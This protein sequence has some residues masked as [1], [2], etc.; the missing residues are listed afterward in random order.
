MLLFLIALNVFIDPRGI[1]GTNKYPVIVATARIEKQLHLESMNP[2]PKILIL[3][4]SHCMRF[5]PE[6]VEDATGLRTFNLSVNSGKIEDFLALLSYAI[7]DQKIT[8]EMVILGVDPRTFCSIEDE[9][10]DKRLISNMTLMNHVPLNYIKRLQKKLSLY[11][12]TLNLNYIKDVKK[13]IKMSGQHKLTLTNYTFEADGFLAWEEDFNQ[14][15]F[16]PNN[17]HE[18]KALIT[19]FSSEREEYF[20]IFLSICKAHNISLK[21]VITPYSP[22]YISYFDQLDG[23][24][25]RFNS[26][27]VE[28]LE[29]RNTDNYFEL[30]DFSRIENYSGVNEFMGIA[31]PSIY[32]STLMLK[33]ILT[34][35]R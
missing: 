13:S 35:E 31:H 15:G 32:N 17:S 4:S 1:F 2:R 33:K 9:G 18:S 19:G 29:S 26:M 8:P 6:V 24:Y 20:D 7:E 28:F 21:I 10:F 14:E 25:S 23:S 11:L 5:S 12:G 34:K 16:F 30:Y 27:L 3:G 22:D